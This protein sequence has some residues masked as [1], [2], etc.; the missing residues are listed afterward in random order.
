[1]DLFGESHDFCK[2]C[3]FARPVS[4]TSDMLCSKK[5]IVPQYHT[6]KKF[7]FSP[8]SLKGKRAHWMDFD[9]FKPEDFKID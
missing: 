1:M 3:K 5:G 9:K 4:E 7:V 6:C 8:L 2:Y